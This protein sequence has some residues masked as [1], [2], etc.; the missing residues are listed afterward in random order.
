MVLRAVARI[1][2]RMAAD[3]NNKVEEVDILLESMHCVSI[4]SHFDAF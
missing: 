2:G 1:T 4:L 3:D